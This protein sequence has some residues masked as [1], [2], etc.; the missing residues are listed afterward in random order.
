MAASG[1]VALVATEDD[2]IGRGVVAELAA[3]GDAVAVLGDDL[4]GAAWSRD[5]RDGAEDAAAD[6]VVT[7]VQRRLGPVAVLVCRVG[8]PPAAAFGDLDP[9]QWFQPVGSELLRVH[10]LVRATLPSLRAAG[11][12]RI[13]MVGS[14]WSAAELPHSTAA[15]ALHGGLV[16]YVKTLAR[17][18][19]R[20]RV[21]V[22]EVVVDPAAP[23]ADPHVVAA[24][25]AYLAGPAAEAV[26]G[27]LLHCGHGGPLRP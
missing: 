21:T 24:A 26:V 12:G 25:V 11:G 20:D 18:L 5:A 3:R 14:G 27:Q 9:A 19:G 1:R 6:E 22:N 2:E 8:L 7:E 15:G 16:A 13:V 4:P 10:R 23:P 17:E